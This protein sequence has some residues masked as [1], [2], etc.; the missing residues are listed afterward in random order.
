VPQRAVNTEIRVAKTQATLSNFKAAMPE[1]SIHSKSRDPLVCEEGCRKF[2][3][4]GKVVPD[5][6]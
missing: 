6:N 5:L 2:Y 3:I 4:E 1:D